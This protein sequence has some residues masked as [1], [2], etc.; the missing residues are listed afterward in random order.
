[1]K[2]AP[3]DGHRYMNVQDV[4]EYIDSTPGTV[5][6][7]CHQRRIPYLRVAGGRRILFDVHE[8]DSWL[9][10]TRVEPVGDS[11]ASEVAR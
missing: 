5:R 3:R 4:A 11:Q 6:Q 10:A 8:I 1:M 2:E 7:L 9:L